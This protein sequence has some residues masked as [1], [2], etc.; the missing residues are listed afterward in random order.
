M[1]AFG[2]EKTQLSVAYTNPNADKS[3]VNSINL[4]V[5]VKKIYGTP[6][7]INNAKFPTSYLN[8]QRYISII[9]ELVA[10]ASRG[11]LDKSERKGKLM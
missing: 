10:T 11:G 4:W 5:T 9:R 3:R 8:G 6:L 7:Y 1:Q 2:S